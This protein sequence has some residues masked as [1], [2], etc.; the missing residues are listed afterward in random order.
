MEIYHG[1][2][3]AVAEPLVNAGRRN[4]DFGKGFY[5]TRLKSQAQKW[6]FLVASRKEKN[7]QGIISIFEFDEECL[8]KQG[9]V[10]KNF[11]AYDIEWLEFVVS[12]R[13]GKDE[14]NYDI[15]ERGVANDQVIDTVEDYED[16]R[17]TAEQAL[18][19]LR[20][21]KPNNQIC[22]RN[23]QIIDTYLHFIGTEKINPNDVV[24]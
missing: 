6:A 24:L 13:E 14:T 3:I 5:T 1:S 10:Y 18:D 21:K 7:P 15:V 12:C 16:G 9:Y 11:P 20:Y 23:Q 19:Q 2:N 17:I 22:F 4:L 8:S